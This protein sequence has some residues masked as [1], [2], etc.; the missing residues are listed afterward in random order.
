MS[1]Q[2]TGR[3]PGDDSHEQQASQSIQA[4]DALFHIGLAIIAGLTVNQVLQSILEECRR[5]LPVDT[6]Y[7]AIYDAASESY[8][9]P[10]FYDLGEYRT[11]DRVACRVTPSLTGAVIQMRHSLYIPDIRDPE[12]MRRYTPVTV[13]NPRRNRSPP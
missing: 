8:E 3:T 5:M 13:A 4:W 1:A 12:A 10:L 11:L 2:H 7:V 6:L 9:V